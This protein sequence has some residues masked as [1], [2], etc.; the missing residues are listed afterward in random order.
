MF[1]APDD[2]RLGEV[3]SRFSRRAPLIGDAISAWEYLDTIAKSSFITDEYYYA[4]VMLK[5]YMVECNVI[6]IIN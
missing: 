2:F 4:D 5:D 6:S 1:V 3:Y